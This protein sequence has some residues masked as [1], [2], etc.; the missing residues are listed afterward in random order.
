MISYLKQ[1]G[2][3]RT[4]PQIVVDHL[5]NKNLNFFTIIST[6]SVITLISFDNNVKI[7]RQKL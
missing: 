5:S 3:E 2:D 4:Q 7:T 1:T 6:V